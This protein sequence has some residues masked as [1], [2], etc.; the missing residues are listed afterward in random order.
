M[1][2]RIRYEY[3]NSKKEKY[4]KNLRNG[5]KYEII[6]ENKKVEDKNELDIS[7]VADIFDIEKIEIE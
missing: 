3:Y 5:Y 6:P 7:D 4:I 1:W 2:E